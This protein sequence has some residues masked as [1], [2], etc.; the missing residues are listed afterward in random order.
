MRILHAFVDGMRRVSAAPAVLFGVALVTLL[1]AVPP[2]LA[3]G[4]MIAESLGDSQAAVTAA[5][6][7]N[8][9]WWR[10]FSAGASGV[11]ASFS[12]R[13]LGFGGVLDNL[14]GMLDNTPRP[15][16]LA[17]I[18][19]AYLLVWIFLAGGIIDRYA[20]NRPLRAAAFF[21]ACGVYFLRFLRLAVAALVAYLLLYGVVHA[22]L[23][24]GLYARA[25]RDMT[26]ERGAFA[27]RVALYLLFGGMFAA[28]S[29]LFDYAKVRAV[30]EDR[31]SMIGALLAAARFIRR[32]PAATAGLYA[33][34]GALFVALLAV[35]RMVAP[36]AGTSGWPLWA[37]LALTQ[38][39]LLARLAVKLLFY[40]SETSLFQASLA[41]A[42]YVAAPAPAWPESPAAEAIGPA[43][44]D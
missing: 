31:R 13:I 5:D 39:Y 29:L 32:R 35:W 41:H 36:G 42:G 40:A 14:S 37:G 28:C 26:S 10:E 3:L 17:G 1:A 4:G 15:R 7:V 11:G 12:P 20:R 18:G 43:R 23:F 27:L 25:T 8:G 30:V 34:N 33:L 19:A 24:D 44:R 22:L 21:S 9:E 6:G 16:V 38:A 2:G